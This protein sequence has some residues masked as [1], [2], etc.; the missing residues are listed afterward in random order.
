VL[1]QLVSVIGLFGAILCLAGPTVAYA[2]QNGGDEDEVDPNM[3]AA[4]QAIDDE[5]ARTHFEAAT[6]LYGVG[7]FQQAAEE[8]QE[9]FRLSNRP[10]LLY[11]VYVAHRDAGNMGEAAIALSQYLAQVP[12]APDRVNLRARLEVME[13]DVA[14]AQNEVPVD[15]DPETPPAEEAEQQP[16]ALPPS[17]H[18]EAEE[19]GGVVELLPWIVTGVGG[20]LLLTG[21]ITGLVALGDVGT[22]EDDCPND[23]CPWDEAKVVD[24]ARGLVAATDILLIS[25]AVITAAGLTWAL[26][27]NDTEE[28][29][30]T[31][32][33]G[34]GP[35]GCA[36][37][38]EVTF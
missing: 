28:T 24:S 20:A 29:A 1:H 23:I 13:R 19:S 31:A 8:F 10:A 16:Y 22:L 33:I 18:E 9:A 15:P 3:Q 35:D 2:Q 21:T 26:F 6:A 11:N 12:D 38:M 14:D 27:F 32:S 5:A 30:P 34:C 37:S 17:P 25:G 7:R 36:A 4:G